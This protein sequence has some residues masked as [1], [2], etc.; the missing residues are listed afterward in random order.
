[1]TKLRHSWTAAV[2]LISD[3]RNMLVCGGYGASNGVTIEAAEAF[4]VS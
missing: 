2:Y 1:M 3:E 4:L